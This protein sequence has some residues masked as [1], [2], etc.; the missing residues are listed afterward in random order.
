MLITM[1]ALLLGTFLIAH[2]A[3]RTNST[4]ARGSAVAT[5]AAPIEVKI[6]QSV[7]VLPQTKEQ[8]KDPFFPRSIRP[9]ASVAVAVVSNAPTLP[10]PVDLKINGTS[11]SEDRPLVIINNVT[12]A[13]GDNREVTT[14]GR[15]VAIQ[16]LEIDLSAGKATVE[17]SG[18]RRVL[19]FQKSK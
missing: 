17:V 16:C 5:N 1:A 19:F 4:A 7:F 9:Y 2:G 18:S 10:P 6:P 14:G 15:R 3:A 11:G 13:V 8:G 12:F